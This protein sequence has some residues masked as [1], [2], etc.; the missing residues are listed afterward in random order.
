MTASPGR[1]VDANLLRGAAPGSAQARADSQDAR[2]Q[3]LGDLVESLAGGHEAG[4]ESVGQ[5]R[6]G[7]AFPLYNHLEHITCSSIFE[8]KLLTSVVERRQKYWSVDA[9]ARLIFEKVEALTR[10]LFPGLASI[11]LSGFSTTLRSKVSIPGQRPE[12]DVGAP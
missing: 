4:V 2:G 1:E 3:D 7:A 11:S 12:S 5:S 10:G 6:S 9:T 8:I